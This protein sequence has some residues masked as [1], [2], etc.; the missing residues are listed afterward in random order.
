ELA[1][2][3]VDAMAIELGDG[4]GVEAAHGA[5][6]SRSEG[7][8]VEADGDGN[9]GA[10]R[11]VFTLG[12][13]SG[14]CLR[15]LRPGI[16]GH[17]AW[18]TRRMTSTR[19]RR[20]SSAADGRAAPNPTTIAL[21][22]CDCPAPSAEAA[23]RNSL[24]ACTA[25]PARRALSTTRVAAV[26]GGALPRPPFTGAW[27]GSLTRQCSPAG[28]PT[29]RQR[30]ACSASNAASSSRRDRKT[31][32]R[33]RTARSYSWAARKCASVLSCSRE[34][35]APAGPRLSTMSTASPEGATAQA[36]PS[37]GDSALL[38]VPS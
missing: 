6:E 31:A 13:W 5:R 26:S 7:V 34:D 30:G 21:P 23:N 28:C 16:V 15:H 22:K 19:A 25:M 36:T 4:G 27:S 38:A 35:A 8:E 17:S 2:S 3:T 37:A 11:H 24:S 1:Q 33:R 14:A 20:D 9:E 32:R 10:G 12:L 18:T 29:T